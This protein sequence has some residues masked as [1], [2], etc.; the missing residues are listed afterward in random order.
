M[1]NSICDCSPGYR[2]CWGSNP[3]ALEGRFLFDDWFIFFYD[4]D[5]NKYKIWAKG[6]TGS[7][8]WANIL[9]VSYDEIYYCKDHEHRVLTLGEF[10]NVKNIIIYSNNRFADLVVYLNT[11]WDK[12]KKEL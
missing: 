7:T 1:S 8:Y 5:I 11:I 3:K 4:R 9:D 12:N 6:R 10:N 2:I